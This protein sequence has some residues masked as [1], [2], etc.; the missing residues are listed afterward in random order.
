MKKIIQLLI[1]LFIIV[2]P[3]NVKALSVDENNLTIEKSNNKTI[4]LYASVTEEVKEIDFTL[5]YTTYDIP[6]YFNLEAGLTDSNPNG[7][8]HKIVFP[9]P[10]TGTVKLGT[11][12][13]N[14]VENPQVTVGTI[15]IHTGQAIT[16]ADQTIS[17]NA[18]TINVKVGESVN[19]TTEK[20]NNDNTNTDKEPEKKEEEKKEETNKEE[21]ENKTSD[22]LLEKIESEIVRI[23][24]KDNIY[25]YKVNINKEVEELDLKPIAK[26]EQ[27]KIETTTQK[28]SEL[29][30]NQIV[31]TVKDGD[32]TEEYKIKVNILDIEKVEIDETEFKSTYEYKGKWMT[33]IV[34]LII[35][36]LVGL[37]LTRRK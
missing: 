10:V 28:I 14:V 2:F 7:V 12:R 33:V 6:A 17:L 21:K 9:E 37:G 15:N 22:R 3:I 19:N 29:K 25:E 1:L 11:I 35:I 27:S 36:L 13:I 26:N 5:V 32:K 34:V 8:S 20:E 31:I 23:E 24:L 30:D 4:S 16:T 18:Q